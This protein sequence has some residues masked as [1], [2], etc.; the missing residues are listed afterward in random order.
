MAVLKAG[1][2]IYPHQFLFRR[3]IVI[4]SATTGRSASGKMIGDVVANK[5]NK[6][7]VGKC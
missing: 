5:N 1:S 2:M 3:L 7:K 4:W 6:Y